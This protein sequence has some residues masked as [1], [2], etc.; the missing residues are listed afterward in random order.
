MH[1]L[2][3]G[4]FK[5]CHLSFGHLLVAVTVTSHTQ[6]AASGQGGHIV[7]ASANSCQ[8]LLT[9]RRSARNGYKQQVKGS[10]CQTPYLSAHDHK[11]R[12]LQ[13]Q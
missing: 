7:S 10:L 12:L 13:V 11:D 5:E 8:A 1:T 4:N 6:H 9:L 3:R 2:S